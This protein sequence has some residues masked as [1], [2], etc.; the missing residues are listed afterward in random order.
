MDCLWHR[1]GTIFLLK[2]LNQKRNPVRD[3]CVFFALWQ[4]VVVM[5]RQ[6]TI[7]LMA[8]VLKYFCNLSLKFVQSFHVFAIYDFCTNHGIERH[9]QS[10]R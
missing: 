9:V 3:G 4:G 1:I 8:F 7:I 2:F 5:L 6:G 10:G